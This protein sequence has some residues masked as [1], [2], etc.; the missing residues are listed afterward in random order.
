MAGAHPVDPVAGERDAPG[1]DRLA[2]LGMHGAH[3][4]V[5]D[6]PDAGAAG[7]RGGDDMETG[8][9]P[10]SDETLSDVVPAPE[11]GPTPFLVQVSGPTRAPLVDVPTQERERV[12]YKELYEELCDEKAEMAANLTLVQRELQ[13]ARRHLE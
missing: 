9:G 7:E 12:R 5:G 11:A 13:M 2:A 8:G 6:P 1:R 10:M 3:L 4:V